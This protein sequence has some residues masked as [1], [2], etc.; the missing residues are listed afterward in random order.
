MT[1]SGKPVVYE[2]RRWL[3]LSL[4]LIGMFLLMWRAVDLQVFSKE[5][6]QEHGDARALRVVQIPAHRGMITDRNGEPLA[7][8]TSVNS[9]WAI[10]RRVLSTDVDMSPLAAYLDTSVEELGKLLK[11]RIGRDFVYLKRHVNPALADK[12]MAMNISGIS[13]EQEFRRYYPAGEVTA[14]LIGFTNIDDAGQEGLELAYND[15][16]KGISGSK[17]VLKDRLGRIVENVESI[18]TPS[19]GKNLELSIDRRIQYLAYRELKAAVQ[20]HSARGGSLVMLDTKTGEVVA[21]VGQPSYNPNNRSD[22]KGE[23]YRN[24]AVTDV[25]EPGSTLKPFTVATALES[26]VY[27]PMTMIDTRPGHFMVGN[28]TIRDSRN[29][30]VIDVATVIKKSSN[31]GASKIAL[32]LEPTQL[33]KILSNAGFGAATGSGFPGE[34]SGYL[35]AS[36]NW[37]EVG[38]ATIAFGYGLSVTVLQLAQAYQIFAT[39]GLLLPVSFIKVKG[40][41]SGKQIITAEHAQ[42]IRIMLETAVEKEGTGQRAAVSGYRVAG[43]T[44]T[45]HKATSGGYSEDRY[46]SLFAGFAPV[47]DPRLVMVIMIDEPHGQQYY[48]GQVAAPVFSRVM[49][50]ALRLMDIPPDNLPGL[51]D[52]IIAGKTPSAGSLE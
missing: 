51:K 27:T 34:A 20:A 24:R 1:E 25:F 44:G 52:N 11:E 17:R 45:V 36:N 16:L 43:K 15:W 39:D 40:P 19:P 10:P 8:S 26:G 13:L 2:K 30:G 49:S 47:E 12:V 32:S 9:I 50:G 48:G 23:Y 28:H 37:S 4:F 33:R 22:M 7:V 6:L 42:Q 14:H 41:V 31:V 38:L 29:Y 35:S 3:V 18:S 21:M 46:L 5:F